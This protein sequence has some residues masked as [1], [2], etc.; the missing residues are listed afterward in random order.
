MKYV[1]CLRIN[2]GWIP[3]QEYQEADFF[4]DILNMILRF[5][6]FR[7]LIHPPTGKKLPGGLIHIWYR[8]LVIK[9]RGEI[10]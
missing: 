9:I 10:T 2:W 8:F 1:D 5:F 6:L 4:V 7:G 3:S